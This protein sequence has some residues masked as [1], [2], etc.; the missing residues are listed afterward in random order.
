M[1]L[2][3]TP[4][5]SNQDKIIDPMLMLWLSL[6]FFWVNKI[7]MRKARKGNTGTNHVK[8]KIKSCIGFLL[9]ILSVN[10]SLQ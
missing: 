4:Q 3:T 2:N 10:Q 9:L 8:L 1:A 7:I 6:L 5:P